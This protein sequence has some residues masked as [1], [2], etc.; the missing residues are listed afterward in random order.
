MLSY[1]GTTGTTFMPSMIPSNFHPLPPN[2]TFYMIRTVLVINN[3]ATSTTSNSFTEVRILPQ[4]RAGS[5]PN[6]DL[7]FATFLSFNSQ[8]GGSY[9][10]MN[11]LS[12]AGAKYLAH[13]YGRLLE[14][15]VG[16]IV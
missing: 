12:Y 1:L 14:N 9:H 13:P 5:L 3:V 4:G 8:P 7:V 10:P 6:L 11:T 16:S 2:F 15:K